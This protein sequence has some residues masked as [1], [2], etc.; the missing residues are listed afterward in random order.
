MYSGLVFSPPSRTGIRM[1][2]EWLSVGL[3]GDGSSCG[4]GG[5]LDFPAE[6][7]PAPGALW[8]STTSALYTIEDQ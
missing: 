2:T 7:C 1:M 3:V 8:Q 5:A 6:S 4:G